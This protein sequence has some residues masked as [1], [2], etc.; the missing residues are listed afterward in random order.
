M[1]SL[2][3][4]DLNLW[5][6]WVLTYALLLMRYL[7]FAGIAFWLFY[8]IKKQKWLKRKIQQR[9]PDKT[10]WHQEIKYSL[11]TFAVFAT[12]GV[13]L[14][15]LVM[16]GMLESKVYRNL[17][18]HSL[19]YF[20]GS[21][22]F[23]ILFHDTYFYWIHRLM[24]HPL[25][26]AKVH[27]VH[28]RSKDPTPWAAFSFH[29]LEAILELGFV[30]LL[31]FT[32]PLHYSSLLMLS[33]WQII[34]NVNGH[35]GFELFPSNSKKTWLKWFNTSTN[36]HMH[37]RYVRCNYGLYFSWWDRLM[38]THHPQYEEVFAEVTRRRDTDKQSASL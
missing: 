2:L 3:P 8:G 23:I 34:F 35:L 10:Q 37:H 27:Q 21:S 25:F 4:D 1:S 30:P 13:L 9:Y 14:R 32:I 20:L 11:L 6:R 18:E 31:L 33:L 24:H 29:P 17:H 26:F 15:F 12:I 5:L 16:H 28:H 7:L 38:K 19:L 22:V 36:H